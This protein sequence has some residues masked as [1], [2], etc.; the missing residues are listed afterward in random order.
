LF[1]RIVERGFVYALLVILMGTP[2]AL[3]YAD[4]DAD[5]Y[6]GAMGT[7]HTP[8]VAMQGAIVCIGFL[9]ILMRWRR[10]AAAALKSWPLLLL[11][12]VAVLS[13]TWS[14]DPLLSLRRSIMQIA[15]FLIGVYLGER[16]KLAELSRI[17]AEVYCLTMCLTFVLFVVSPHIVLQ[18]DSHGA[19]RGL[20]QNKNM[21]GLNMAFTAF[22][23]ILLRLKR[24]D[25][26]RYPFLAMAL[27]AMLLSHSMASILTGVSIIV[28]LPF[29]RVVR[30]PARLRFAS[31]IA[32]ATLSGI[33][34]ACIALNL[35][36]VLGL[37]GK[38]LTLTG[39]T[40]LWEQILLAISHHPILG[41]GYASFWTGLRGE[42][43]NV[44]AACGWMVPA[45]HNGYL[46]TWLGLGIPGTA[47]TTLV[48]LI[49]F[50]RGVQF[51]RSEPGMIAFLPVAYY[52][53]VL[54]H[55]CG[56]SDLICQGLSPTT[57][58]FTAFYTA[59][60]LRT[61]RHSGRAAFD[62]RNRKWEQTDALAAP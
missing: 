20:T 26:I 40:Q 57:C 38:T 11:T 19:W 22:L 59:V 21:F 37:T 61:T 55:N 10:V 8:I 42:S 16:Y 17:V 43:L 13:V 24:H 34:A 27:L 46:E 28:T 23:L 36:F 51:I 33:V 32:I 18:S 4:V 60:A 54:L 7:L 39:R 41:Y 50:W 15:A 56:E 30:F 53:F 35:R 58:L 3:F 52:C 9:L 47:A 45:A 12:A 6:L 49:A 44:V 62:I 29:W 14:I 31:T 1:I 2:A 5:A 48:F 25:W